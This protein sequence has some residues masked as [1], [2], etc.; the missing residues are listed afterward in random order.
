MAVV[1]GLLVQNALKFELR[2]TLTFFLFYILADFY[3]SLDKSQT[4]LD[5]MR[6]FYLVNCNLYSWHFP[7]SDRLLDFFPQQEV[8]PN[9][10]CDDRH[11]RLRQE[12]YQA[13][14]SWNN[15]QLKSNKYCK[16]LDDGNG[17]NEWW[18]SNSG[19]RDSPS[20]YA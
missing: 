14:A 15:L 5:T 18:C 2:G 4:S 8:R 6:K 7:P 10:Q 3:S 13:K 11:C 19:A 12:E 9:P 20:S 16:F 17:T 1:A